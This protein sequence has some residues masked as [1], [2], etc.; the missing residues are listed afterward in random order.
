[1]NIKL[2]TVVTLQVEHTSKHGGAA[3]HTGTHPEL[4][5]C[6]SSYPKVVLGV[7]NFGSYPH[8]LTNYPFKN[9]EIH[10]L[11]FITLCKCFHVFSIALFCSRESHVHCD[12]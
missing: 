12:F 2:C 1:M 5:Y 4:N 8:E 6:A 3:S 9:K 10:D 11:H 7:L